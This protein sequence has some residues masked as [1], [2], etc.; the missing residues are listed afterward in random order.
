MSSLAALFPAGEH[1][2]QLGLQK[3]EPAEFFGPRDPTGGILAERRRWLLEDAPRYARIQSGAEGLMEET[4]R[5][6]NKWG[7]LGMEAVE[8]LLGLGAGLEPDLL[9]LASDESGTHRLRGGVLCFPTGWA[10]EEKLG[11]T[12]DFIHGPVPGLNQTVGL[13]ISQF[14]TRLK[15][16]TAC[17]RLNWGLAATS[18]LNLHPARAFPRPSLPLNPPGLWLR[19]EQ[20]MLFALPSGLGL[21]FAIRIELIGVEHVREDRV[22]AAGLSRALRSMP[23]ALAAYKGLDAIRDELSGW[24]IA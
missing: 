22:A 8:P 13:Q 16:G 1:R 3:T 14:L 5:L 12:M 6:V 10:L 20:Q 4:R 18:E 15:P 21:L 23:E 17:T 2:F 24:L 11:Q 7:F 9:W 19:V